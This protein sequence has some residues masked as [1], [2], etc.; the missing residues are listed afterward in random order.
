M[1]LFNKDGDYAGFKRVL[2]E[3]C[4]RIP[5][6]ILAYCLMPN[7]WHL[8]LWPYHDGELSRFMGWLTLTHTQR[9][10]AHYH[11]VGHG[12]LYQGRFKSFVVQHD[13]HLLTVCRYVERNAVRAGLVAR[14]GQWRWGS[15][16]HHQAGEGT[17]PLSAWPIERPAGWERWVNEPETEGELTEVRR[18]VAKG[19]PFGS[20]GW[21]DQ[22]V[23]TWN[24]L[25][26]LRVR[27]RPKKAV[28]NGS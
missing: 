22:M 13:A 19:Q 3:A 6:R 26:T 12:H 16:W 23:T 1:P 17:V 21:A 11:T 27:G 20:P 25:S 28:Q 5:L 7:H 9:W 2:A 10:H 18:S 8:V 14:A 4:Q 24:L 15:G